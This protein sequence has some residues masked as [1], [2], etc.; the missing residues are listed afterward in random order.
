MSHNTQ[1]LTKLDVLTSTNQVKELV[2]REGE[3]DG[4]SQLPHNLSV[5]IFPC[6]LK[7]GL[8]KLDSAWTLNLI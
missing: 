5:L 4:T 2:C 8:I 3:W 1:V 6:V 7:L